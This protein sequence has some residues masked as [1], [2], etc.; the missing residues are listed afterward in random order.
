MLRR[1]IETYTGIPVVGAIPKQKNLNIADRHLGLVPLLNGNDYGLLEC[2]E[3]AVAESPTL[4]P[5]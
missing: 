3:R 4:M 5:L 2:L 1:S